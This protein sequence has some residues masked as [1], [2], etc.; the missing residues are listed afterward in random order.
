L[1]FHL[2]HFY[3]TIYAKLFLTGALWLNRGKLVINDVSSLGVESFTSQLSLKLNDSDKNRI[4][5]VNDKL[6]QKPAIRLNFSSQNEG[7]KTTY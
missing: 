4:A 2:R 1:A 5:D 6:I 7:E 3:A